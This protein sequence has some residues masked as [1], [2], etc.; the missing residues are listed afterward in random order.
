[1][2]QIFGSDIKKIISTC[3]NFESRINVCLLTTSQG[4]RNDFVIFDI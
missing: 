1:M 3:S 4:S 2:I